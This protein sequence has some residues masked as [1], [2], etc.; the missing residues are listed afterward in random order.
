MLVPRP[1]RASHVCPVMPSNALRKNLRDGRARLI[2]RKRATSNMFLV[3]FVLF[4]C[5]HAKYN[6][7]P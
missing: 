4:V 7:I 5:I 3:L 6:H 2:V 1:S